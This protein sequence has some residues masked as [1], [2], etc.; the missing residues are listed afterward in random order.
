MAVQPEATGR[1]RVMEAAW[2]RL[3]G[4]LDNFNGAHGIDEFAG[5]VDTVEPDGDLAGFL[6]GYS[7]PSVFKWAHYIPLYE[8][9]FAPYRAGFPLQ[10]GSRRPV[11]FLEIGVLQGGSLRLWRKYFGPDA[12]LVGIDI[13]PRCREVAGDAEV[14]IGSQTDA[15][16]LRSVVQEM[17]GVDIVLDDGSH[18]GTDTRRAFDAL[19]PLLSDGGLYVVEDLHTAYWLSFGWRRQSFVKMIHV[20]IDGMHGWYRSR[21]PREGRFAQSAVGGLHV[22]DSIAFVDKRSHGRPTVFKVGTTS[23]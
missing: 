15:A 18:R 10:D 22:Y 4:L 1:R 6:R 5:T 14:R 17:G 8:R 9:H 19:F 16:F 7:G 20:M 23:W 13:D 3:L 2:R 12:V 21:L 11:R